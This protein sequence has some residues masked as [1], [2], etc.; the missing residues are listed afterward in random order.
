MHLYQLGAS[1][2]RDCHIHLICTIS[3]VWLYSSRQI[4]VSTEVKEACNKVAYM[5]SMLSWSHHIVYNLY[6]SRLATYCTLLLICGL[7][8]EEHI[9]IIIDIN[10]SVVHTKTREQ[11]LGLIHVFRQLVIHHKYITDQVHKLLA[12]VVWECKLILNSHKPSHENEDDHFRVL[13]QCL[14]VSA[15]RTS[16]PQ[17]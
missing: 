10:F 9:V 14:F 17:A 15:R 3:C 13:V 11:F 5:L 6:E 16:E 7:L 12:T 1:S 2:H 8:L 4:N